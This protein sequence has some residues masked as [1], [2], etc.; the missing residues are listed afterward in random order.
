MSSK[1]TTKQNKKT[2]Q[3]AHG[4]ET[5]NSP[6][7][8]LMT[9]SRSALRSGSSLSAAA[10][11]TAL[12]CAAQVRYGVGQCS[13][14]TQIHTTSS[15]ASSVSRYTIK[16]ARKEEYNCSPSPSPTHRREHDKLARD[17]SGWERHV[18]YFTTLSLLS[19]SVGR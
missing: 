13:E 17:R 5:G 10:L 16:S 7:S 12:I 11:S 19:L 8:F 2:A 6:F 15:E 1:N 18:S 14:D 4:C 9:K 3:I